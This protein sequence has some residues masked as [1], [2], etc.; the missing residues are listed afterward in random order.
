[1]LSGGCLQDLSAPNSVLIT[2]SADV[3]VYKVDDDHV[4]GGVD[5]AEGGAG[6]G[7]KDFGAVAAVFVGRDV[8]MITFD[9]EG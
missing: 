1:M 5:K 8:T 9:I 6:A 4:L 7:I 2:H 3:A